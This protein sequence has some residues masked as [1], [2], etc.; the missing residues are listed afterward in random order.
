MCEQV[1]PMLGK[2][3][4]RSKVSL[5]EMYGFLPLTY[6]VFVVAVAVISLFNFG[7]YIAWTASQPIFAEW[8]SFSRSFTDWMAFLFPGLYVSTFYLEKTHAAH[9]IPVVSNVLLIN[10]ALFIFFP[11]CFA[12]AFYIDYRRDADRVCKCIDAVLAK[13]KSAAGTDA[14]AWKGA[15]AFLLFFIPI[16]SGLSLMPFATNI[17][18]TILCC[19]IEFV[20]TE[21]ILLQVMYFFAGQIILKRRTRHY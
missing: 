17:S 15:K 13:V 11:I 5:R 3:P 20:V 21:I 14:I 19:Y 8:L 9:L 10:F 1:A 7:S 6:W 16:Y 12:A 4:T 2:I 18:Y